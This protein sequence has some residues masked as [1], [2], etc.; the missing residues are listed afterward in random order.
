M[1][2]VKI[3]PDTFKSKSLDEREE[4]VDGCLSLHSD[5]MEW[6]NDGLGPPCERD[7]LL[8]KLNEVADQLDHNDRLSKEDLDFFFEPKFSSLVVYTD[9]VEEI[10]RYMAVFA[11][12]W[13]TTNS[14]ELLIK[15]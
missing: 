9:L 1:Y 11:L 12:Y 4:F 5:F 13:W 3:L 8:E 7:Y 10:N 14:P 15:G 6:W 2:H